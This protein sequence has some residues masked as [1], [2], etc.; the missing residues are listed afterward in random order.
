MTTTNTWPGG[1]RRAM[2]QDEHE[3]WNAAHYP[4]TRQLC[5]KCDEPTGRCEEDS[6]YRNDEGPLCEECA[7]SYND[8]LSDGPS[9]T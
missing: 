6:I 3:R 1:Y 7:K 4:G 2:H 5:S 9:K 8:K